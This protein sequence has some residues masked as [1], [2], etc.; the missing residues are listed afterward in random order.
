MNGH[1]SNVSR[2][3]VNLITSDVKMP[4]SDYTLEKETRQFYNRMVARISTISFKTPPINSD[5]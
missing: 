1:G 2:D 3:P 4:Q 5:L